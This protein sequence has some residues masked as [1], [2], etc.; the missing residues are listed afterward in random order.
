[1]ILKLHCP[2]ET[3][4]VDCVLKDFFPFNHFDDDHD[5]MKC[6]EEISQF[7]D[8]VIRLQTNTKF[9]N[10]FDINEDDNDIIEYHSDIDPDKCYF[11]EY[12]YKLF[13]NCNY[14]SDDSFNK[15]L[16]R[17]SMTTHFQLHIWILEVYLQIFLHFY[18]TWTILNTALL[19]LGYRKHG[20]I[21]LMCQ[22]MASVV[23]TMYIEREIHAKVVVYP[24]LCQK[25]LYTLKWP[26]IVWWMII[27]NPCL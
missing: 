9:F 25:N 3:G 6:I 15:Y 27:L 2:M 22:P 17:H 19:L 23:I 14:Y 16:Y 4:F 18:H 1:M 12:S 10:P 13:K 26:T 20:W 5:F 21:Q 24:C 11:N 7:S 8:I